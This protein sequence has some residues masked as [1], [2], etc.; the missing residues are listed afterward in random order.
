MIEKAH[1][2]VSQHPEILPPMFDIAE[3]MKDYALIKALTIIAS[4]VDQLADGLKNTL[5]AAKSDAMVGTL[6]IY[7]AV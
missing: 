2:V 6:E 3:F 5:I 4:R 1:Y 7:A